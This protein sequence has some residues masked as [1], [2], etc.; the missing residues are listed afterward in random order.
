MVNVSR[1]PVMPSPPIHSTPALLFPPIERH[2]LIGDRR[3]AA[4]V[5][6]DGTL[7]WFCA[8]DFD[9]NAI[10]SHLLDERGGYCR[11][12]PAHARLGAQ[13]YVPDTA[14]LLTRWSGNDSSGLELE[15]LDVMA[16]PTDERP[17]TLKSQRIIIRRLKAWQSAA[18]CL[19]LRPGFGLETSVG[20]LQQEQHGF[21]Y[22]VGGESYGLWTSFPVKLAAEGVSAAFTLK[23]G[24]EC[25]CVI[26]WNLVPSEWSVSLAERTA[27]EAEAYWKEWASGLKMNVQA[28]REGRVRRSAITVQLLGHAHTD[29]VVAA[30]TTSLPARIGGDLNFDYRYA[31]VRDASLSL[32]LLATFQKPNE[33]V[34]YLDWLC[35][36]KSET[37]APLQV[38]YRLN[39]STELAEAWLRDVTGYKGSR[40]V[41]CGNRAVRQTQLGSLGFLAN[42]M[43]TYLKSGGQWRQEFWPL[44]RS[45]AEY[46]TKHWRDKDS[47]VWELVEQA[48]YVEGKVMSWETLQCVVSIAHRTHQGENT[49]LWEETAREIHAEVMDLGWCAAKNSFRQRYESDALDAASLLVPLSG[50]LP[51]DHPRV[52]GTL[53]ALE[54]ELVIDGLIHRFNP[55]E[56]LH[57]SDL[58]VSEY[59]GAFLP[60]VF[61]HA[62][63]LMRAG[64]RDQA[65]AILEKCEAV[66]GDLGLFAEGIDARSQS[67]LGNM[68]LLFSHVEYARAVLEL[69]R[70]PSQ[71]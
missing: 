60:A 22:S 28:A 69:S 30:P 51:P 2:G 59:E 27:R 64:R 6:A 40:P 10:F 48:H 57:D 14:T 18:V 5:A 33:V 70:P 21:H 7:D 32:G 12:G 44:L 34:R 20:A 11:M 47:G 63:A 42:C 26:G 50:F 61:W 45:I 41:R 16:W 49:R 19:E 65:E 43:C 58:S 9:G 62:R 68:P 71:R 46:T 4:L 17:N 36:L 13:T 55:K 24:A 54:R 66:S 25:W 3:T 67:F 38:C 31:W 8:P 35:G 53:D 1:C 15:L 56:T 52:L 37:E 23:K 29:S 39:G